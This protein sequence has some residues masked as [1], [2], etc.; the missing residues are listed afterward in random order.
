MQWVL[1]NTAATAKLPA[2]VRRDGQTIELTMTLENGWRRGNIAW[3][4]TS[5]QLRQMG[6]GGMKLDEL[7]AEDR[8]VA[9]LPPDQMALKIDHVGEYGEHAI[10]RRAGFQRGDIIVVF[11][12]QDRRMTE[13]QLL[14]YTL[15]RKH[16]GDRVNVTV[17][18]DGVRKTLT[19]ALP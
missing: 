18:R 12:G 2:R 16:R 17:L 4:P 8:R 11:D 19:Y 5:W 13:S 6:L 14:D 7:K 3:R 15:R 1:H 10:A 9:Q